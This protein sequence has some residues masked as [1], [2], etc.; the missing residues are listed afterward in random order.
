MKRYEESW[1]QRNCVRFFRLQ[2]PN[3]VLFAVPNGGR[4]G[5]TEAGIMKGEGVLAGVSDLFLMKSNGLFHGLFIE[6]KTAKGRQTESQKEF[7]AKAGQNGYQYMIC[8]SLEEF[9]NAVKNYINN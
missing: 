6:I 4:R 7:E 2:Y 1:I 5:V 8:R 9:M 3:E